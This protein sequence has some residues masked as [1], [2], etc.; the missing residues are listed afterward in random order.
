MIKEMGYDVMIDIPP[1]EI[2]LYLYTKLQVTVFRERNNVTIKGIVLQKGV[3]EQCPSKSTTRRCVLLGK[4]RR[5]KKISY[6]SRIFKAH[7]KRTLS[8]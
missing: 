8:S 2:T 4:G 1:T 5:S 3:L 7:N 6:P